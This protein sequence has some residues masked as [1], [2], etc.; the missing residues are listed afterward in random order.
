MSKIYGMY[1][2][3][4]NASC[5]LI[6]D[7]KITF[8]IE[9]ER[10]TRI[11]AGL[12]H[13]SYPDLSFAKIQSKSG[14]PIEESDYLIFVDPTPPL[15]SK[16]FK[17]NYETLSHHTAHNYVS[18]FLSG[19]DGK[20]L[21][22]SFDGGGESC[23]MKVFLCEDGKM[24][25]VHRLSAKNS[26]SLGHL[27]GFVTT[28]IMG[29]DENCQFRWVTL[30]DEGKVMGMAPNGRYDKNIQKIFE[31]L[32]SYDNLKFYPSGVDQKTKFVMEV[33]L[34]NGFFNTQEKREI[35]S[36]NL[37]YFTEKL[38]FQFLNDLHFKYP[39]YKKLCFSGGL[40]SNVKLNQKINNL[41]WVEEIFICPPMG[42]EGLSLGASIHKAVQLGEI[43]K[44]FELNDVFFG[45]EYTDEEI[46]EFSKLYNFT[47]KE[48]T[49]TEISHNLNDGQI[50][51][52]FQGR[53][54]A[55]PRSL[56]ARSILV[57]PTDHEMHK[58][59]NDRLNRHDTMPFAPMVLFEHFET[60]F[61]NPKSLYSAEF[62][63]ITYQTKD[64][65]IEKIPAV[66][67]KSDSTARPQVIKKDKLP[68]VWNLINEY[69]NLSGIPLLLNTS[70]NIHN[71]PII[72][73]PSQAFTHLENGII[74]KLVIGNYVYENQ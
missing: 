58:K 17:K 53:M 41:D 43:T 61:E 8:S 71:E 9:E 57:R 67:Q 27:W 62:M 3:G 4:H 33:L 29:R 64:S 7:G 55:G 13:E 31:S 34:E 49:P 2:G 19:M 5:S 50:I 23:F 24:Y 52:W 12:V 30:K 73:S 16:K 69:H 11:K 46:F 26:G 6:V 1:A 59:L 47:R 22:I 15:Y 32:I 18:Y 20:V 68:K 42:D 25:E 45:I 72:E 36:Y 35:F 10:L 39:D 48:Y 66:I 14:V 56:G 37:Q 74:D 70:F 21:S 54:E 65:W 40:F 63:T 51:G 60:I 44:P 28:W 38:M